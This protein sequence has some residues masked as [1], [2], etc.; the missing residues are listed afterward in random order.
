MLSSQTKDPITHQATMNLR[1][2]LPGGLTLDALE[3][4]SVEEIDKCIC[5]VGFHNTKCVRCSTVSGRA[6]RPSVPRCSAS[7][8][9]ICR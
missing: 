1:N 7:G 3:A 4:A 6:R 9:L 2:D 8:L 5:K